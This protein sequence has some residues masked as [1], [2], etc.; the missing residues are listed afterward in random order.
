MRNQAWVLAM[1]LLGISA[2]GCGPTT[3]VSSLPS[4]ELDWGHPNAPV[5]GNGGAQTR[6]PVKPVT[7]GG[8]VTSGGKVAVGEADWANVSGCRQWK[9]IVIHHSA[10]DSGNATEF[11]AAHRER[12]W[13]GLGYHFVI[14][15]GEG[16]ANGLVEVGPRWRIQKWGAHTGKTPDN[17]YNN[18][19]IGICL[20][21]DLSHHLPSAAQL[22]S[23]RRL[24]SYLMAKYDIPAHNVIGH[25]DAPGTSTECPGDKLH[26]Y[27]HSTFRTQLSRR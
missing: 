8:H 13:D 6:D 12:G 10:T 1:A 20:V 26:A 2:V 22:E 19:G 9:Y 3:R 5:A 25:R 27:I 4:H 18:H 11:D 21:G 14:D 16:G 7:G 17:E 23:M 15:N 24:V